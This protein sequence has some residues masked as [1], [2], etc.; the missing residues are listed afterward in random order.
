MRLN[1][2]CEAARRLWWKGSDRV[3]VGAPSPETPHSAR[4]W[5]GMLPRAQDAALTN[6]CA[7]AVIRVRA[8]LWPAYSGQGLVRRVG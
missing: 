6:L 1:A 2:P 5:E 4:N 3:T 7:C 8:A